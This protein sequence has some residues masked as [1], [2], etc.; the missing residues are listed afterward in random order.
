[1]NV[2]IAR[3]VPGENRILIVNITAQQNVLSGA[4]RKGC[5]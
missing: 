2:N 1:M 4:I 5:D 3:D